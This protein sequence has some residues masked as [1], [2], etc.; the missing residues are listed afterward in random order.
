ML[1]L[2]LDVGDI[3]VGVALVS[4]ETGVPLEHATFMRANGEA[5]QQIISFCKERSV[6]LVVIGLPLNE[7]DSENVQCEKIRNFSRR[8][9]KRI[10]IQVEYVD[11]YYSSEEAQERLKALGARADRPERIDSMAAVIILE[12]FLSKENKISNY[13]KNS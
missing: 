7:D 5:E 10:K 1:I 12:R 11:E 13:N 3:R 8:L 4:T 6:E 2:G 9:L